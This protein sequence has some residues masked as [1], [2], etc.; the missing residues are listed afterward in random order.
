LIWVV[1]SLEPLC[2]TCNIEWIYLYCYSIN[3]R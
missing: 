1:K 3:K 2:Y